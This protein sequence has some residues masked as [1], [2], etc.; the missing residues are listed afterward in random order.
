MKVD[1]KISEESIK[2]TAYSIDL[3]LALC[4]DDTER[5][6]GVKARTEKR[7]SPGSI[8]A[9]LPSLCHCIEERFLSY[10]DYVVSA[11]SVQGR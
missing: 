6:S 8:N 9:D 7:H 11:T 1:I 3:F 5:V 2:S 10:H 4:P